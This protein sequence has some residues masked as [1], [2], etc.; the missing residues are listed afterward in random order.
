V[1]G[2]FH[3][4]K[5]EVKEQEES[6]EALNAE[7]DGLQEKLRIA[8]S[9]L[10]V[11]E[12]LQAQAKAEHSLELEKV[13]SDLHKSLQGEAYFRGKYE[14]MVAS[15]KK[16]NDKAIPSTVKDKPSAGSENHK[17]IMGKKRQ[18]IKPKTS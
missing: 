12:E 17:K 2:G 10:A 4:E 9:K 13:R 1:I 8:E 5:L 6:V 16:D 7:L 3:G 11:L 14:A 15:E 18:A